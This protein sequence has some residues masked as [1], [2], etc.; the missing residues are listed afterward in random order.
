MVVGCDFCPSR[1]VLLK[2]R[3][4]SPDGK[5]VYSEATALYIVDRSMTKMKIED[6]LKDFVD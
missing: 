5:T 6:D 2:G 1:K 4:E 3:L